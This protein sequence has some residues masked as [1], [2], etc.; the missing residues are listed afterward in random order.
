ML[1]SGQK[2]PA[3]N[4]LYPPPMQLISGGRI[5]PQAVQSSLLSGIQRIFITPFYLFQYITISYSKGRILNV[6]RNFLYGRESACVG[7]RSAAHKF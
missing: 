7:K 2:R 1:C 6:D 5:M 3:A 4:L